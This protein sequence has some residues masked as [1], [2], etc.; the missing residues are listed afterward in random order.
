[1]VPAF[2]GSIDQII[3]P[4]EG[5]VTDAVNCWVLVEKIL[6]EEGTTVIVT[7]VGGAGHTSVTCPAAPNPPGDPPVPGHPLDREVIEHRYPPPPPPPPGA[8]PGVP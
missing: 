2:G 6:T 5:P 3:V 1:M 8:V 7:G 4:A